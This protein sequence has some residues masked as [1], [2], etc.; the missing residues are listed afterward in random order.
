MWECEWWSLYETDAPVKSYLRANFSYK[1]HLSEEQLLQRNIDGRPF[2]YVQCDI[3]VPK[4]L[5]D[6]F[7]NFN[8][9]FKNTFLSRNDIGDLMKE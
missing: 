6:Y 4:H 1:R 5:R 9:I 3:E 8:P 7:S 2:G